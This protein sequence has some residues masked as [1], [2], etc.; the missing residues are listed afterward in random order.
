MSIEPFGYFR[1][2]PCGWEDCAETDEGAQPL[3]D[4]AT[5]D[6]LT[7][8]LEQATAARKAAQES[9]ERYKEACVKAETRAD[10]A[11]GKAALLLA[12][13]VPLSACRRPSLNL[14]TF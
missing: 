11:Q 1:A 10:Q 6:A 2:L 5:V 3:Y 9:L 14:R 4:Q 7:A 12:Q 13:R 8:Q